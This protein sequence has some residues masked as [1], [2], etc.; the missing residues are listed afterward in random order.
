MAIH[1]RPIQQGDN[2][3]L[4]ETIKGVF[5]EFDATKEG[6]VYSDPTTN[7]LY[8]L[9]Q[10]KENAECWVAEEKGNI[11]GCCGVYPTE[12]LPAGCAEIVKFYLSANARGKGV[13]KQLM[14]K[15]EASAI[16]FG[17]TQLYIESLPEFDKAVRIY[18]QQGY[19]KIDAPMGNSGHPGCTIWMVK[20]L[21]MTN[22]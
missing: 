13:G 14:E 15:S 19:K 8:E 12:G 9:F 6:T 16:Q 3:A 18:E 5:H 17:Y 1:I 21:S 20:D 11:L 22:R 10:E 2:R 4:A 7:H